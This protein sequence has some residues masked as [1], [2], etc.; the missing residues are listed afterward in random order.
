[1]IS[2]NPESLSSDA[3]DQ[4]TWSA[5]SVRSTPSSYDYL[6]FAK[7]DLED[8]KENRHLI[9]SISN[10]KRALH[11]RLEDLCLGFG[12]RDL[13]KLK[14]SPQLLDYLRKCGIVSPTVLDRLNRL[15]N[16][17]EHYYEIPKL[18]EVEIFMD[19]TELFL[20][21]TNRWRDRQPCEADYFQEVKTVSGIFCI[22]GLSFDWQKGIAKIKYRRKDAESRFATSSLE[23]HSPSSEYFTCVRFLISNNY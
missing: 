10:V 23:F 4:Y 6:R 20:E 9:N 13:K 17:V 1:M 19:V 5:M 22:V 14:S 2:F 11:L 18:P 8:G 3:V 15:R 12:S 16:D 21:A 7:Q